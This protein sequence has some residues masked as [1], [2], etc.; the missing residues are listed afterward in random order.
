MNGLLENVL[1]PEKAR[2]IVYLDRAALLDSLT[3]K[4]GR[5]QVWAVEVE[6]GL[7]GKAA[8]E[9]ERQTWKRD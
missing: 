2:G 8:T 6:M 7:F 4:H 3:T 5:R 1:G 9:L